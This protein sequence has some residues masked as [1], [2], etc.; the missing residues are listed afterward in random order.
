MQFPYTLQSLESDILKKD[1]NNY[2]SEA[3][4]QP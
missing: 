4:N 2:K 1:E 3:V